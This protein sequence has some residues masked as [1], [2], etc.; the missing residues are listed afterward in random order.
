M[1]KLTDFKVL[2]LDCYGTL[3]DWERGIIDG[4]RP[5]VRK[6]DFEISRDDLLQAYARHEADQQQQTPTKSYREVLAVVYR[7]LAEEF[8]VRVSWDE[9]LA[10]GRTINRWPAFHDSAGA[11]QYLRNHYKLMI[12]SNIDNE[13]FGASNEKLQVEFNAIYTAEDIGSYKPALRNFEYL[14][15]S[16]ERSGIKKEEILHVG[17]SLYHDHEPA[18]RCGLATCWIHRRFDQPGS[19]ATLQPGE[20]PKYTFQFN[21]MADFIRAHHE[22]MRS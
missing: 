7:R 22:E 21:S 9:C 10:F 16:L 14:L 5:L 11:L 8:G 6:V 3:I 4:L 15:R 13:S 18:N 20:M 12:L 17:E 2:T 1:T 19:G